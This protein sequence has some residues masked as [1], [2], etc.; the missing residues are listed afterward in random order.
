MKSLFSI[1]LAVLTAL[2]VLAWAMKP[3]APK[4]GRTHM[5]WMADD[6]PARREQL[7]LF[8]RQNPDCAISLDPST[9][10]MASKVVIQCLAGVGPDILCAFDGF[11]VLGYVRS[12][13]AWDVTDQLAALG[14]D[15]KQD[16]WPAAECTFRVGDRVFGFPCNAAADAVW[17]NKDI[18]DKL[19][20][21]YPTGPWTWEQFVPFAQRLVQRDAQGK[22]VCYALAFDWIQQWRL[23]VI[24]WGGHFY[25][26]DGT[27]C[28]T[29][30]PEV[31][32]A[33]QFMH[34]LVYKYHVTPNPNEELAIATQGGWGAGIMT[35]FGE[36]KSAMAVGGRWWLV[37]LREIKGLR[38]GAVECPHAKRRVFYGYG[39]SIIINKSSPRREQAL[40]FMQYM[41]SKEYNQLINH[42]A[43]AVG[44]VKKY[45]YTDDF[46][47]DPDYP[48]EDFNTVWREVMNHTEQEAVSPFIDAVQAYGWLNK[49]IDLVKINQK[50]AADAMRQLAAQINAQIQENIANNPDLKREYDARVAR[51][52]K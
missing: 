32:A 13:I 41:A 3:R 7:A 10:D 48:D 27:R 4:D 51:Q 45:S 2:S 1:G 15:M 18:L 43:D 28:V 34:D 39:K 25:S 21:Q 12:G 36:S 44:P 49:Q 17:F 38:L 30:S 46:L 40:R 47:H 31:I 9:P 26:A 50:S 20:V 16:V 19:G 33:T 11:Q 6:A 14:I 42:Q 8:H 52:P 23:F 24:Q 22:I 37:R 5:I 35:L 29:D